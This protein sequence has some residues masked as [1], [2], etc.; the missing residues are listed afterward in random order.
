M[1][2]NRFGRQRPAPVGDHVTYNQP[3]T[4][5][6]SHLMMHSCALSLTS[7]AAG[8]EIVLEFRWHCWFVACAD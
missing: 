5:L 2:V 8:T 7:L 6:L 4:L 1:S 3:F